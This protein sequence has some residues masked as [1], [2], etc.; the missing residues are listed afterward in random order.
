M[1]APVRPTLELMV[2]NRGLLDVFTPGYAGE[3][4]ERL[5][6]R[7]EPILGGLIERGQR[8]GAVR[9][10]IEPGDLCDTGSPMPGVAPS[11]AQA[12]EA[13]SPRKSR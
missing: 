9:G 13:L 5:D 10:E 4:L 1:C 8:A 6:Q 2:A 11:P 7:I 3:W 12:R